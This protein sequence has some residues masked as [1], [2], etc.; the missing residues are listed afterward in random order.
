MAGNDLLALT[1]IVQGIGEVY[2]E[3]LAAVQINTLADLLRADVGWVASYVGVS[4]VRVEGWRSQSILL[5]LDEADPDI[6]EALVDAGLESTAEVAN[7]AFSTLE[8]AMADAVAANRLHDAPTT[9]RLSNLHRDAVAKKGTGVVI[10]TV[11]YDDD[12]PNEGSVVSC[13]GAWTRTDE[14][15]A[16]VLDAV[17]AG[18]HRLR[19]TIPGR[20]DANLQISAASDA[21]SIAI[22]VRI[23]RAPNNPPS[24]RDEHQGVL[25]RIGTGTEF[26]LETVDFEELP[27]DT[28]VMVRNIAGNGSVR[29]IELYKTQTG[30]EVV[31]RR[32]YVDI[33]QLPQGVEVGVL[34]RR[35]QGIFEVTEL[36]LADVNYEKLEAAV[37]PLSL[38][39]S[40]IRQVSALSLNQA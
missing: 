11:K 28:Y 34:L 1:S 15:G 20:P 23:Q 13:A 3:R 5:R 24:V 19:V 21:V 9:S 4:T 2:S 26:K 6:V 39:N 29:L 38:R 10:G 35:R 37:G 36:T 17:P 12:Q 33:D 18:T 22:A 31:S 32:T 16:F 25:V 27:D 40:V 30:K 14:D 8:G 7:A